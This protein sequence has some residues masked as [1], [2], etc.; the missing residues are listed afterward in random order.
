[1]VVALRDKSIGT[2][3]GLFGSALEDLDGTFAGDGEICVFTSIG[4]N[5]NSFFT[6]ADDSLHTDQ[7][8]R[9]SKF[10]NRTSVA[11]LIA[12]SLPAL[13]FFRTFAVFSLCFFLLFLYIFFYFLRISGWFLLLPTLTFSFEFICLPRA[14][15]T[16]VTEN[17]LGSDHPHRTP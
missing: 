7:D 13:L 3:L 2:P 1:M 8:F 16:F 9:F 4:M 15:P 14:P 5:G 10:L 11:S 17:P 6:D 12:T